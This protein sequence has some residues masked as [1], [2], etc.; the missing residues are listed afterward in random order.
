MSDQYRNFYTQYKDKLFR[1]LVY[2]NGDADVA[3]DIMQESFT[4]HFQHYGNMAVI[5]PALLFT[6]ARNVLVDFQ[7]RQKMTTPFVAGTT[8]PCS[9]EEDSF[10]ARENCALIERALEKLPEPDRDILNLAANG[11]AYRDIAGIFETNINTVK[12]R[13][14]RARTRLKTILN[15]GAE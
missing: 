15:S 4:R 11:V 1:Y 3:L 12:V 7:R 9:D 2:K 5:S 14:H 8:E 6:I 13:V 10:I